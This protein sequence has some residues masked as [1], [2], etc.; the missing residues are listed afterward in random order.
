MP[1][2]SHPLLTNAHSANDQTP[3]I[4]AISS[5]GNTEVVAASAT[6]RRAIYRWQGQTTADG[7]QVL[8]LKLGSTEKDFVVCNSTADGLRDSEVWYVVEPTVAVNINATT[9]IAAKVG[10]WMVNL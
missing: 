8:T 1:L 2:V 10:V 7:A 3:T 4:A 6:Q 5:S 9:A